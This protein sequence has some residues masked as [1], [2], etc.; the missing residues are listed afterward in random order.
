VAGTIP[1]AN[2]PVKMS[3][4]EAGIKGPPP[5]LGQDTVAVFGELLGLTEEEVARLENQ[6]IVATGGGPDISAIT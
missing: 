5:S 3:R 6:A 2:T 1:I 4:S